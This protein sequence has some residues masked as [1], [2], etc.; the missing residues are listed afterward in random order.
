M[1]WWRWQSA[2]WPERRACVYSLSYPAESIADKRSVAPFRECHFAELSCTS[3]RFS[4]PTSKRMKGLF[5][6]STKNVSRAMECVDLF[7]HHNFA[8]LSYDC[9]LCYEEHI[10]QHAWSEE[11][12]SC[13]LSAKRH[14]YRLPFETS[15]WRI[16]WPA[17]HT[18]SQSWIKDRIRIR[19][20][21][22]LNI[23]TGHRD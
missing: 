2:F 17:R 23:S 1:Q 20:R 11:N 21:S 4:V 22:D 10:I 19:F 18:Q 7:S 14:P 16:F 6:I 15:I 12:L 3:V 5:V 8:H 9:V 13:R